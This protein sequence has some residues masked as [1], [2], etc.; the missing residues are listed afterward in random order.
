MKTLAAIAE[1]LWGIAF[2][3][4]YIAACAVRSRTSVMVLLEK[5]NTR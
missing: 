1:A 5:H 3:L 2:P 4:D